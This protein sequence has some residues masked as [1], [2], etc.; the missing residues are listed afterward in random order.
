MSFHGCVV[1]PGVGSSTSL[2]FVPLVAALVASLVDIQVG[3]AP[4]NAIVFGA[5]GHAM[6]FLETMDTPTIDAIP[7]GDT[8]V[9][10]AWAGLLQCVIV[11][12]TELVKCKLQVQTPK[13]VPFYDGPMDCLRQ[14]CGRL[15]RCACA[16]VV[17]ALPC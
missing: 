16:S 4:L 7:Y 14:V 15:V 8:C 11:T 6:R 10:G 12:P 5:Y 13:S 3:N 9:A 17:S 2:T 1:Q